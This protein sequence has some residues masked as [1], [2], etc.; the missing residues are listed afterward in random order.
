MS[1]SPVCLSVLLPSGSPLVPGHSRLPQGEHL[2][3]LRLTSPSLGASAPGP[4]R[5]SERTPAL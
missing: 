5:R 1:T 2:P 4:A 3:A